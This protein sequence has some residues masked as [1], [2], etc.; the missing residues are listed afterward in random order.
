LG[1]ERETLRKAARQQHWSG[2]NWPV[3]DYGDT[4]RL[5]SPP[6]AGHF[7]GK[8]KLIPWVLKTAPKLRQLS[9]GNDRMPEERR[10]IGGK[11]RSPRDCI[12]F[13]L[14]LPRPPAGLFLYSGSQSKGRTRKLP[15]PIAS[16][17]IHCYTT[18]APTSDTPP[19]ECTGGALVRATNRSPRRF[20][21]AGLFV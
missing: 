12:K 11:R 7:F 13:P 16:S 6:R 4:P 5:A 18:K 20:P 3:A 8:P 17:C 9:A 19:P 2:A 15:I 1:G 10:S 14:S 21:P